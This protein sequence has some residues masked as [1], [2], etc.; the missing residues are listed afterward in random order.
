MHCHRWLSLCLVLFH[1]GGPNIAGYLTSGNMRPNLPDAP[2]PLEADA[3]HEWGI[4]QSMHW[5]DSEARLCLWKPSKW[6]VNIHQSQK[7][8]AA[9]VLVAMASVAGKYQRWHSVE[10]MSNIFGERGRNTKGL[11]CNSVTRRI[12]ILSLWV[13]SDTPNAVYCWSLLKVDM[14]KDFWEEGD[15]QIQNAVFPSA[16]LIFPFVDITCC[17]WLWLFH[18]LVI[19]K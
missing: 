11:L 17:G 15:W 14:P 4:C 9:T 8:V 12:V 19:K 2:P 10:Q 7:P 3:H 1:A 5:R 13:H 6:L 16:V 18:H